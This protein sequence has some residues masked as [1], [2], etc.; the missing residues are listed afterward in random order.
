M[1]RKPAKDKELADRA[2]LLRAWRR[3]HRDQLKEALAGMHGAVMARLMEE[4]KDLR[5][6]RKLVNFISAQNWEVID[7]ETRLIAL[8]EINQAIMK[9]RERHGMEPFDDPLPGQSDN[10]S[11]I[12]KQLFESF[13]SRAGK[14][15]ESVR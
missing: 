12:I 8:H 5:E 11:R 14:T 2:Y 1:R 15:T 4:L 13:P 6:A 9:L 3:H 7:A 10:A